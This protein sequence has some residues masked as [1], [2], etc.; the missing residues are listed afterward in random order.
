MTNWYFRN[1]MY[2]KHLIPDIISD[3]KVRLSG[4]TSAHNVR[5]RNYLLLLLITFSAALILTRAYFFS[6]EKT[7]SLFLVLLILAVFPI[8]INNL[9]KIPSTEFIY[10]R[11]TFDSEG[12]RY[13]S[14]E[15]KKAN[16]HQW[17]DAPEISLIVKDNYFAIHLPKMHIPIL[18]FYTPARDA[19]DVE[20]SILK[21]IPLTLLKENKNQSAKIYRYQF[22]ENTI[23]KARKVKKHKPK[24][25]TTD[26]IQPQPYKYTVRHEKNDKLYFYTK[27][28]TYSRGRFEYDGIKDVLWVKPWG[29]TGKPIIR[30]SI[31]KIAYS[32]RE[33]NSDSGNSLIG[34]IYILTG[35]KKFL[36]YDIMLPADANKDETEKELLA[37]LKSLCLELSKLRR[38]V[39]DA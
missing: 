37:D 19:D 33:F 18:E 34:E 36:L 23:I 26:K 28:N 11:V 6:T 13:K 5:Q 3:E 16:A 15:R 7:L 32:V 22:D 10:D 30:S 14:L 12:I 38:N 20:K 24:K 21:I 39:Q 25:K 29:L 9:N 1:F 17:S 4:N 2:D 8:I 31:T 27:V 35:K